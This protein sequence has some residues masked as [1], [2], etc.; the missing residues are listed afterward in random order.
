[1]TDRTGPL[2]FFHRTDQWTGPRRFFFA[3]ACH[4]SASRVFAP[5][6]CPQH[7]TGPDR[8]G[9]DRT[10]PDWTGLD[11][12]GPDWTG[13]DRTGPLRFFH[14]SDEW[15]GP[16]DI[17]SLIGVRSGTRTCLAH[18][19]RNQSQLPNSPKAQPVFVPATLQS[20]PSP[21]ALSTDK[22]WRRSS[23]GSLALIEQ[24]IQNPAAPDVISRLAAV[25]QDLVASA[26]RRFQRRGKF[27]HAVKGAVAIDRL[28]DFQNLRIVVQ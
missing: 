23:R 24:Q 11:R 21:C 28:G 18:V 1:M 12:T 8:T 14:R 6:D 20:T 26:A 3:P 2:Q 10:G 16:R 27:R 19:S 5:P 13:L 4:G 15:T 9:L 25:S 7:R 22:S 17:F